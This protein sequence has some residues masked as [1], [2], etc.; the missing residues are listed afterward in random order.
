MCVY[1]CVC[2]CMCVCVCVCLCL[3][4]CVCVCVCVCMR[5][6]VCVCV[7]V[8]VCVCMCVCVCVCVCVH[9][10]VC[11]CVCMWLVVMMA[12]IVY[13]AKSYL[14]IY[15]LYIPVAGEPQPHYGHT[16][17]EGLWKHLQLTAR[18]V[19]LLQ[20]PK[21]AKLLRQALEPVV[22]SIQNLQFVHMLSTQQP[23]IHTWC[24]RNIMR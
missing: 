3:C 12:S 7:C 4:V 1:V 19:Q 6:C 23:A 16:L 22:T 5:A 2:V 8:H 9:V 17:G 14:L 10:C 13:V 15:Q 24:I 20:L 18:H 11:A 21:P